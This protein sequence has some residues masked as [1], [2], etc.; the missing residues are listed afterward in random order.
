MGFETSP[1]FKDIGPLG[2]QS[3][4]PKF[5]SCFVWISYCLPQ[6][7]TSI[8]STHPDVL[9]KCGGH[10]ILDEFW[11]SFQNSFPYLDAKDSVVRNILN[12][13]LDDDNRDDDNLG[14]DNLDGDNLD[15][16]HAVV[17]SFSSLDTIS[18]FGRS[19]D[20]YWI[21]VFIH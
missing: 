15:S 19:F 1:Q 14:G 3:D 13:E 11:T 21:L 6:D 4:F 20:L 10:Q 18:A 12:A 2:W 9:D 16:L 5:N 8:S 17:D 7:S